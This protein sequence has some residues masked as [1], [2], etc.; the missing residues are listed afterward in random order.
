MKN[1][2]FYLFVFAWLLFGAMAVMSSC[3][4]SSD[5]PATPTVNA[6]KTKLT[7]LIDSV[8]TVYTAAVE[9]TKPGTYAAGSK[10][11]LKTSIDLA[12]T[13]KADAAAAQATVNTAEASLRRAAKVFQNSLIQE[14]SAANLVAQWKFAGNAN[15]ATA[16]GNN[17]TLKAGTINGPTSTATV[18]VAAVGTVMPQSVP[19]RFG[20]AGQAY[21]FNS[22]AYIE[23]PYKLTL[24]PQAITISAWVKRIDNNSDNYIVSLNRWT[25]YKFQLQDF[26]KPFLTVNTSGGI[27]NKDSES[28]IVPLNTWT[29]VA[30]SYVSGTM[31]FYVNGALVKTWT[32]V[33]G[34]MAAAPQPVPL[35][36]GQQLPNSIYNSSPTGSQAADY[37]QFYGESFFKGQMDD[38]RIYNR[39][40]T[41]AE[42]Q[43]IFTIE[44]T[45]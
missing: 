27:A 38:I 41:D 10:A 30:T 35:C 12:T 19:D 43:S 3:S 11:T 31:K 29:H 20:R 2:K 8:N 9:G 37:F 4:K 34:A 13:T 7:A 28:G 39:A 22:G 23:V 36:I 16:N 42:V 40:L 17:G 18:K 15:D 32:D 5:S 14:V 24:N 45:L 21:E 25:S 1:Q 6:D 33:T 44:N 26:G